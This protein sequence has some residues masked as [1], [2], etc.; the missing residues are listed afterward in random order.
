MSEPLRQ[1][2]DLETVDSWERRSMCCG[3]DVELYSS[4]E[5]TCSFW[6]LK[7]RRACDTVV[8]DG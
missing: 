1:G 7:C 6:C 3:A 8:A 4:R 2:L 5:G